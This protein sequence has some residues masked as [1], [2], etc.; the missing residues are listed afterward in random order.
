MSVPEFPEPIVQESQPAPTEQDVASA[1]AR[2]AGTEALLPPI[3]E[4]WRLIF[5]VAFR[6]RSPIRATT[7]VVH[8]GKN[9]LT[10]EVLMAPL[11]EDRQ[12]ISMLFASVAFWTDANAPSG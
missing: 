11:S 4:R 12:T 2:V 9:F 5:D 7:R 8:E 10:A 6:A 3:A 1:S